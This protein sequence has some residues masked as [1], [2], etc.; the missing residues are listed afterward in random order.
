MWWPVEAPRA[1]RSPASGED[2]DDEEEDEDEDEDEGEG[3]AGRGELETGNTPIVDE[4]GVGPGDQYSVPSALSI[5]HA[6]GETDT[7][8]AILNGSDALTNERRP[9]L[10][11]AVLI[12]SLP[13]PWCGKLLLRPL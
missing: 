3:E 8:L 7:T 12:E 13:P 9:A 5:S 11:A 4:P 6:L 1:S 2:D 10:A